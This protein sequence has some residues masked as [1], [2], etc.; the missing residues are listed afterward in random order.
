MNP[1]THWRAKKKPANRR[2]VGD[3]PH[4]L[5][6][7]TGRALVPLS[8]G[9]H[10]RERRYQGDH[11]ADA[12]QR[13]SEFRESIHAERVLVEDPDLDPVVERPRAEQERED[14]ERR[15][16]HEA[17]HGPAPPPARRVPVRVEQEEQRDHRDGVERVLAHE[18]PEAD[19]GDRPGVRLQAVG[20][21]RLGQ[22]EQGEP[23]PGDQEQPSGPV[24]RVS[25]EDQDADA[26]PQ[27][28]EQEQEREPRVEP[29]PGERRPVVAFPLDLV[30]DLGHPRRRRIAD[31]DDLSGLEPVARSD[32]DRDGDHDRQ[33]AQRP[34]GDRDRADRAV[35]HVVTASAGAG[36]GRYTVGGPRA[37]DALDRQGAAERGHPVAHDPAVLRRP[38]LDRPRTRTRGRGPQNDTS[39]GA[40]ASVRS[41]RRPGACRSAFWR[42]WTQQK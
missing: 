10:G 30:Q 26:E 1:R 7:L 15:A 39:P 32:L 5:A 24:A 3:P 21:E 27:H 4:P 29:A 8:N 20:D 36:S 35:A 40:W 34:D 17:D 38:R 13:R 25:P 42:A 2:D 6:I 22:H 9:E 12:D 19:E 28:Q 37:G 33:E 23:E 16:A 18:R 14:R 11:G 41:T 31:D